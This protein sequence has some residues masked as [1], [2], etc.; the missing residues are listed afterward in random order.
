MYMYFF[1]NKMLEREENTP[2]PADREPMAC[3][4][5]ADQA[6]IGVIGVMYAY[7]AKHLC[8]NRTA[9]L[10]VTD[11]IL[12]RTRVMAVS[13]RRMFFFVLFVY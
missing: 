2:K 6:L 7:L 4:G 11:L 10:K 5:S 13:G 9:H 1:I 12:L 8:A 3:R